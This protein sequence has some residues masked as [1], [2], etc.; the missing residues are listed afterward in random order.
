MKLARAMYAWTPIYG[1]HTTAGQIGVGQHPDK[2]GSTDTYTFCL[3]ACN[4]SFS[5][6][7]PSRRLTQ[8]FIDFHT[9]VV[10]DGVDPKVAHAA[11]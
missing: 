8:M 2:T 6:A 1:D 7:T 4:L 11:F 5:K 9:I 10:R 3:G